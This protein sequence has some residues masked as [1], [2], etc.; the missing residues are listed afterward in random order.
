MAKD[1]LILE[2]FARFKAF[3]DFIGYSADYG[4]I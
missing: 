3:L 1:S 4:E 2:S